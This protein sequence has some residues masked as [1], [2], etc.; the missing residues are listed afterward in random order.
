[1]KVVYAPQALRDIDNILRL[2]PRAQSTWRAQCVAGYRACDPD[3]RSEPAGA[4]TDEPNVYRWPLGRYRYTVFY[5]ALPTSDQIE[6]A[7]VIHS[8]RVKNLRRLPQDT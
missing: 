8:A 4:R 5:R 6:V 3:V 2:H 1:M 7:R